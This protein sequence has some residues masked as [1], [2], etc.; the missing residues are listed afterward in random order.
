MSELVQRTVLGSG[1]VSLRCC[2]TALDPARPSVLI[3]LPFGVPV[4]L[5]RAAFDT[6]GASCNVVT[7]ESRYILNPDLPF[8]G[9]EPV[10][11]ATHVEDMLCILSE[12]DIGTCHLLGYCAGASIALVA[13][14]QHPERFS[15]VILVNGEYQL[16]KRGYRPNAYQRSFDAFLPTVAVG[17]KQASFV[18]ARSAEIA[19]ASKSGEP[20]ELDTQIKL[21]YSNEESLFRYART[22]MAYR[23]FDALAIARGIRQPTF[24]LA[25]RQDMHANAEHSEAIRDA[26][27]G[28][29]DFFDDKGDHYEFCRVGS[30][31]LDRI[32]A[33]L[34]TSGAHT[35]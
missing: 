2:H 1:G 30:G 3:A 32:G 4:G 31:T 13:A 12:L 10:A 7:W 11:P 34:G 22:Y 29:R 16:F 35:P 33:I 20:S 27:P 15:D 28:A 26:I 19:R 14:S 17:R 5:A 25:S 18:F 23:G 9:N 8:T 24:V 6:I 21:P